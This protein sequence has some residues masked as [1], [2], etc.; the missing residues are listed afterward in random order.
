MAAGVPVISTNAGGLPEINKND[1]T[2]FMSNVG[3]IDDMSAHA[4][5][6]LKNNEML[7]KFKANAYAQAK[8]FDIQN[9]VPKYEKLYNRFCKCL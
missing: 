8:L 1:V 6:L 9:I 7:T 4:I 3:D 2:G 5:E